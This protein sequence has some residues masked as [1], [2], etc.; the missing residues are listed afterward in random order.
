MPAPCLS[1]VGVNPSYGSSLGASQRFPYESLCLPSGRLLSVRPE[2]R[3]AAGAGAD[4]GAA[5]ASAAAFEESIQIFNLLRVKLI[6]DGGT[7]RWVS[8]HGD[9][10]CFYSRLP[11]PGEVRLVLQ[12]F[13]PEVALLFACLGLCWHRGLQDS[14]SVQLWG[15][16]CQQASLSLTSNSLLRIQPHVCELNTNLGSNTCRTCQGLPLLGSPSDVS[17]SLQSRALLGIAAGLEGLP[18][19][20]LFLVLMKNQ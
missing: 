6:T 10:M 1:Q 9:Q 18:L 15:E 4:V 5:S 20:C 19:V 7:R 12:Q 3:S 14:L 16:A 11:S 17:L 2:H 8:S 13:A